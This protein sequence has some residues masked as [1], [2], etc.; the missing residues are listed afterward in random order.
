MIR[1][2]SLRK[3]FGNPTSVNWYWRSS[4]REYPHLFLKIYRTRV[5]KEGKETEK[6]RKGDGKGKRM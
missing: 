6:G 5:G 1:H 3:S 4:S 2:S